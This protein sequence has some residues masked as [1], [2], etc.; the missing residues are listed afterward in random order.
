M[1]AMKAAGRIANHA[2]VPS[3]QKTQPV[4]DQRLMNVPHEPVLPN[5]E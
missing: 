1:K 2:A 4:Y 5:V 3:A